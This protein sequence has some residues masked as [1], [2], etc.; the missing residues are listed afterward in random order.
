MA[1]GSFVKSVRTDGGSNWSD[2]TPSNYLVNGEPWFYD[3]EI[4]ANGNF[5]ACGETVNSSTGSYTSFGMV[6]YDGTA[7]TQP[8]SD[9]STMG[10]IA[11]DPFNTERVFLFSE[12]FTD[13]YRTTQVSSTNPSWTYSTNTTVASNIPW[14][15]WTENA[16]FVLGE[17]VFDPI[18]PNKIWIAD[19]LGTWSPTDLDDS[20]MTWEEQAAGQ[21]HLVSNDAAALPEGEVVTLHW[22]R[23]IY[24]HDDVDQYPLIYQPTNRFNSA[25]SIDQSPTDP[26]Y[27]VAII[28]DHRYCCY[29]NDTRSSGYSTD[30]GETW[31]KFATMPEPGNSNLIFGEIA[32]SA[33]NYKAINK[34]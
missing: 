10:E 17:I 3:S 18:I 19:G 1:T 34:K 32:V 4:D 30:G 26:N 9:N 23:P 15:E 8:F 33:K 31:I 27:L 6:R 24:Y 29:D 14:M 11:I 7:W 28:E 2:I 13:I 12:G 16:W 21:E 5:Y 20:E 22:D 25:W